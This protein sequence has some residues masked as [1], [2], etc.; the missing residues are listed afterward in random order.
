[1]HPARKVGLHLRRQSCYN[2][3]RINVALTVE[4]MKLLN[5]Q[6]T[7]LDVV[8]PHQYQSGEG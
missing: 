2:Q 7:T 5:Y 6:I 4:D 1:M 3:Q 8:I